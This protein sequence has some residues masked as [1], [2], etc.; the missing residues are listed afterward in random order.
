MQSKT[1]DQ[2]IEDTGLLP[3]VVGECVAE[4]AQ[5]PDA[6]RFGQYVTWRTLTLFNCNARWRRQVMHPGGR[7]YLYMFARHWL[8]AW[9]VQRKTAAKVDM[10]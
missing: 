8:P 9:Q 4:Q 10:P 2:M 3:H 5:E 6:I 7:D 1:L